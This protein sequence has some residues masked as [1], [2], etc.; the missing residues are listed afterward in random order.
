MHADQA[1]SRIRRI[2]LAAVALVCGAGAAALVPVQAPEIEPITVPEAK[3]QTSNP[4]GAQTVVLDDASLALAAKS[5]APPVVK[6]VKPE[7]T[8]E[9]V[10]VVP[11]PPMLRYLGSLVTPS[12]ARALI[13]LSD[14]QRF[15]KAGD[16]LGQDTVTEITPNY[17]TIKTGEETKRIDLA[18]R[19]SGSLKIAPPTP[20]RGMATPVNPA[21]PGIDPNTGAFVFTPEQLAAQAAAQKALANQSPEE[22]MKK[23]NVMIRLERL[24]QLRRGGRVD[25]ETAMRARAALKSGNIEEYNAMMNAQGIDTGGEKGEQP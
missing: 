18:P 19:A 23:E 4:T 1:R 10:V 17:I 9:P 24:E 13:S 2:Q 5:I 11:P 16:T 25:E 20:A 22:M 15:V 8:T 6:P 3:R 21:M 14:R 7:T 12:G